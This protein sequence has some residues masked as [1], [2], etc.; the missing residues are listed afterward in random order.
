MARID[1][2]VFL[3]GMRNEP[4]WLPTFYIDVYPV[5]NAEYARFISATVHAPPQ[6]WEN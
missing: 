6:H 5:T 4:V 3:T 1:G 2:S